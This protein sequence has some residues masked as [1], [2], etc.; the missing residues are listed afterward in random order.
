MQHNRHRASDRF[1]STQ[2]R[3]APEEPPC[4]AIA[5]RE[6]SAIALQHL[7]L[8]TRVIDSAILNHKLYGQ[9]LS[10]RKLLR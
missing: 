5:K 10:A 4:M 8:N 6:K 9:A 2:Q 1:P 3:D 7:A